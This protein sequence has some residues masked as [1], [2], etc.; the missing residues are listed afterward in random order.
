MCFNFYKPFEI[1]IAHKL[2]DNNRKNCN[3]QDTPLKKIAGHFQTKV[4]NTNVFSMYPYIIFC[5]NQPTIPI[6]LLDRET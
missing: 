3:P 4:I 5:H 6:P 2:N 1:S